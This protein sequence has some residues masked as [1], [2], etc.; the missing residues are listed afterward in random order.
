MRGQRP[1][2]IAAPQQGWGDVVIA[3]DASGSLV[4]AADGSHFFIKAD[5][6]RRPVD[7]SRVAA[8]AATMGR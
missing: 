1:A 5:G 2:G 3:E 7:E 8:Y 6:T 4:R